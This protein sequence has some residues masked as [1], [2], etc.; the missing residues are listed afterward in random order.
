MDNLKLNVTLSGTRCRGVHHVEC[1]CPPILSQ[2][3]L[4]LQTFP[5]SFNYR[6]INKSKCDCTLCLTGEAQVGRELFLQKVTDLKISEPA[7]P[8]FS[9]MVSKLEKRL[10]SSFS[11][12]KHFVPLV[13][14][15]KKV[16]STMEGE[17]SY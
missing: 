10:P 9:H 2:I 17:K 14:H 7:Q 8:Y 13:L 1:T 12:L 3:H 4:H 15:C 16:A 6:K 11:P 5:F